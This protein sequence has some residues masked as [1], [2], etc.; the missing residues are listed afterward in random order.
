M[1]ADS[2]AL[3]DKYPKDPRAH[4]FRGLYLLEQQDVADAEPYFR[5]AARLGRT[6]PVM[7]R[8]F[9]D[10]NTA[11][12]ALTVRVQHRK[13]RGHDDRRA[14]LRRHGGAGLTHAPDARDNASL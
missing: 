3:V 14:A 7:T 2:L 1:K 10:W 6:S 9:Q 12:L 13:A 8:D 4:L 5:D 11:L